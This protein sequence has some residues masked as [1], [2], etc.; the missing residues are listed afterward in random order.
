MVN[1]VYFGLSTGVN[2]IEVAVFFLGLRQFP[3]L[4]MSTPV[5]EELEQLQQNTA[6]LPW[7][8]LWTHSIAAV[9]RLGSSAQRAG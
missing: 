2:N 1:S 6:S 9:M 7:K 3:E 5:L 8:V 4:S